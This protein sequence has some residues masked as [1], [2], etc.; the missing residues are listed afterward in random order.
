[1]ICHAVFPSR[2]RDARRVGTHTGLPFPAFPLIGGRV[3]V[4]LV[5]L[6]RN[7]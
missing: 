3:P 2:S 6:I 5:R 1:M 4:Q 7:Y